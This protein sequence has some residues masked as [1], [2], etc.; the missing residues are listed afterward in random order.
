MDEVLTIILRAITF[1]RMPRCAELEASVLARVN[2][3]GAPPAAPRTQ[4]R[5]RDWHCYFASSIISRHLS[6]SQSRTLCK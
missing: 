1:T 5:A 6:P 3:N 4:H 2:P